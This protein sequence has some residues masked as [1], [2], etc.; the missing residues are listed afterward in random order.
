[1]L[2]KFNIAARDRKLLTFSVNFISSRFMPH[3]LT[4]VLGCDEQ[5]YGLE[6]GIQV[7]KALLRNGCQQVNLMKNKVSKYF[8]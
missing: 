5:S 6:V 1:M 2:L 7:P 8:Q 4:T 3:A